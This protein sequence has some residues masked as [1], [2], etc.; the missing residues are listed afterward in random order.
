MQNMASAL[1]SHKSC[2]PK[3]KIRH[4]KEVEFP[5]RKLSTFTFS[6]MQ[7]HIKGVMSS[8]ALERFG[9][10]QT[11]QYITI[12]IT[13]VNTETFT[14]TRWMKWEQTAVGRHW[15]S[16]SFSWLPAGTCDGQMDLPAHIHSKPHSSVNY[17]NHTALVNAAKVGMTNVT[18]DHTILTNHTHTFLML[19]RQQ[20]HS[21]TIGQN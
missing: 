5:L 19:Y 6:I 7:V 4:G 2:H 13:K 15:H 20:L 8:S 21:A 1:G 16:R 18:V 11:G 10:W 3:G 12:V 17:R 9:I 14:W